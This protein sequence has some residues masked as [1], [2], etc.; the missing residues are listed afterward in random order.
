MTDWKHR[1]I[2][3]KKYRRR[4]T[5]RTAFEVIHGDRLTFR[6]FAVFGI[7]MFLKSTYFEFIFLIEMYSK[8]IM[9]SVLS[10]YGFDGM[11]RNGDCDISR[12][13]WFDREN[14]D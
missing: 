5:L 2:V 4:N 9:I 3:A 13:N 12:L 7:L 1:Q 14:E 10:R 8:Y 11:I 6:Y